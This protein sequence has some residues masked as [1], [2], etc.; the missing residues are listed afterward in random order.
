MFV[1]YFCFS[2]FFCLCFGLILLWFALFFGFR[3]ILFISTV[4]VFYLF[5]L[6]VSRTFWWPNSFLFLLFV[7]AFMPLIL[8]YVSFFLMSVGSYI[9]A[10]LTL[11]FVWQ[12]HTT[13]SPA[14][15]GK[16]MAHC[17]MDL[18]YASFSPLSLPCTLYLFCLRWHHMS[19]QSSSRV[20]QVKDSGV[21][22]QPRTLRACHWCLESMRVNFDSTRFI[23]SSK[24]GQL[25][26][27][28]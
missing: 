23:R 3:F 18:M 9:I 4:P 21:T 16:A 11:V 5:F 12:I 2:F 13:V 28:C 7:F 10:H 6:H 19:Y 15:S 22:A 1:I 27:M 26:G 8:L 24:T 20:C 25:C 14:T 17:L